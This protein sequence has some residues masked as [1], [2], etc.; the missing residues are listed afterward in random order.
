MRSVR[1][2]VATIIGAILLIA[3]LVGLAAAQSGGSVRT[4]SIDDIPVRVYATGQAAP[5]IV[6]VHGFA[7]SMQ[8]MDPL[9]RSLMRR[10]F[11]VVS[12][13]TFGHGAHPVPLQTDGSPRGGSTAGLQAN[14]AAVVDWAITQPEVDAGRLTLLGH[15]MGAGTVVEYAVRDA[16]GPGRIR[17]T[18]AL[19]LPSA[20]QIPVDRPAIPRNLLLAV[21]ALEPANFQVATLSGLQRAYPQAVMGD[22]DGTPAQ[23]T[24]RSAMLIPGVEHIGILFSADTTQASA[25]WIG[26][27]LGVPA[28][29]A[30]PAPVLAWFVV[31]LI[32]TGLLLVPIGRMALGADDE[33]SSAVPP[34][35]EAKVRGWK[36]LSVALAA[37]VIASLAGA[38]T[39]GVQNLLPLAV[40]GYVAIWFLVAGAGAL[41]WWAYRWRRAEPP[42]ASVRA[43][44]A[45]LLIAVLVTGIVAA[46]GRASWAPFELVGSRPI[47]LIALLIAFTC[48]FAADALLVRGR[49][50]GARIGLIAGSR[51]IAV[52]V[53]LGSIPLLQAPGFLILLLPLM[54]ILLLILGWYGA[55]LLGY[56]Q[57]WIAATAVQSLPL[58]ALVATTFPLIEVI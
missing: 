36:V 40:G 33:T 14:L 41:A 6:I 27:A 45:G 9:A 44:L 17:A 22:V 51:F 42:T 21:G 12:Y 48:Y 43:V 23:G 16:E 37:A 32:G 13:D 53:I 20:E 24:A 7:G 19:S 4:A 56:R 30:A 57:G 8:L 3:S 28:G 54:V 15:S 46:T 52:A 38:A 49:G 25:S 29:D 11:T 58:A 18:V 39:T 31:A 10:G 2:I 47:M 34:Q 50:F 5:T 1:V 55:V 26:A 35:P